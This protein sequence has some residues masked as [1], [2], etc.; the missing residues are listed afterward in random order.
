MCDPCLATRAAT[1]NAEQIQREQ[2]SI[3]GVQRRLRTAL[4]ETSARQAELERRE[5]EVVAMMAEV[6]GAVDEEH[7]GRLRLLIATS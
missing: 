4:E 3:L 2:E 6:L 1:L 5:A 7:Q